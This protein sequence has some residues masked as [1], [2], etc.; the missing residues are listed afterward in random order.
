MKTIE[1]SSVLDIPG[2]VK[3]VKEEAQ[4]ECY[5]KGDNTCCY[6][7][8]TRGNKY[9]LEINIVTI[10]DTKLVDN[11]VLVEDLINQDGLKYLSWSL[12]T[13]DNSIIKKQYTWKKQ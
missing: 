9:P 6:S 7:F 2:M 13:T 1:V 8:M 3:H 10:S 4:F 11:L 5:D 12:S